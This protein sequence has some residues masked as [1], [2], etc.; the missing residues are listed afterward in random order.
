MNNLFAKTQLRDVVL[1]LKYCKSL[2][3]E[4]AFIAK[5]CA[6]IRDTFSSGTLQA[7]CVGLTKLLYFYVLGY[8]ASYGQMECLKMISSQRFVDK[9][10]G[11]LGCMLLLDENADIHLLLTNSLQTDLTSNK[12]IH[13]ALAL[14]AFAWYDNRFTSIC[15]SDMARNLV[16]PVHTLVGHK[17]PYIKKKAILC[18]NRMI[19]KSPEL[20]DTFLPD[21]RAL[22]SHHDHSIVHCACIISTTMIELDKTKIDHFKKYEISN[23]L[24]ELLAK[25]SSTGA[26]LAYA[27]HDICSPFIQMKALRLLS[28]LGVTK[29]DS[30]AKFE[31]YLTRMF[32]SCSKD[33]SLTVY[34]ILYEACRTV[35]TLNL[36]EYVN[37]LAIDMLGVMLAST[38]VCK[39]YAG[40]GILIKIAPSRPEIVKQYWDKIFFCLNKGDLLIQRRCIEFLFLIINENNFEVILK[41]CVV[42][43]FV[44]KEDLAEYL[45]S[46]ILSTL[47]KFSSHAEFYLKVFCDM[48]ETSPQNLDERS[49]SK[50]N[51][52]VAKYPEQ[53]GHILKRMIQNLGCQVNKPL[54][55]SF[56][57]WIVG[58]YSH[59]FS[60]LSFSDS[61]IIDVVR[62]YQNIMDSDV[63]CHDTKRVALMGLFKIAANN[64]KMESLITKY[65]KRFCDGEDPEL[66]QRA[67][68]WIYLV[69]QSPN[70]IPLVYQK[71][72][73]EEPQ[74]LHLQQN[75]R[76]ST[77]SFMSLEDIFPASNNNVRHEVP[78][79]PSTANTTSLIDD[80]F[81]PGFTNL[82]AKEARYDVCN[83]NGLQLF[84]T[85]SRCQDK[86]LVNLNFHAIN[87][88][89][90]SIQ[91]VQCQFVLPSSISTFTTH[92]FIQELL[93]N[94]QNELTQFL[95]LHNPNK[96]NLKFKINL[97]FQI[98]MEKFFKTLEVDELTL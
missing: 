44:C 62:E 35:L 41:R 50:F 45:T 76:E 60:R 30:M 90:I 19:I 87:F 28:Y 97:S 46:Q 59:L 5:E 13:Q 80:L 65:V 86:S 71:M 89:P 7:Q 14:C 84:F 33:N 85:Y 31:S 39:S 66:Q 54:M 58:E 26:G 36:G 88:S 34:S 8:P 24:V 92:A 74:R 69:E 56:S 23:I 27:S 42:F 2:K 52:L 77:S 79:G 6:E 37:Q 94:H 17:S 22:F 91:N 11:Y 9:R 96:T 32:K 75:T 18:A 38:D 73:A 81:G 98:G 21:I 68:E 64:P 55:I 61:A 49:I 25:L 20:A 29:G 63:H 3:E 15:S 4:K 70:L 67:M 43:L 47:E 95:S 82:E 12:E 93:P 51:A 53:Q 48:L 83:I 72:S 40:L 78:L 16:S 57:C 1:F 10:I